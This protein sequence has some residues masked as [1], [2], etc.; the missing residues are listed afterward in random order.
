MEPTNESGCPVERL[1]RNLCPRAPTDAADRILRGLDPDRVAARLYWAE[2]EC[3]AR[4]VL[5]LSAVLALVGVALLVAHLRGPGLA[6]VTP[7]PEPH[8][9]ATSAHP[10]LPLAGSRVREARRLVV[11]FVSVEPATGVPATGVQA[12]PKR[13]P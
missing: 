10:A 11:P 12:P 6:P 13:S 4:T 3:F 7:E 9:A 8:P 2:T 5:A 1:F